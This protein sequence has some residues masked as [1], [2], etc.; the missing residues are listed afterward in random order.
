MATIIR[1]STAVDGTQGNSGSLD[2]VF[3]PDSSKIAFRSGA[4]NLVAGDTNNATDIFVKDL[5]SDTVTRVSTAADGTQA[6]AG[7]SAISPVFSPDGSKIAFTSDASNLVAG[8]TNST[9]DVF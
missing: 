1:V 5:A 6:N 4:S 9:Y 8:D 7:S 3:S 2:P